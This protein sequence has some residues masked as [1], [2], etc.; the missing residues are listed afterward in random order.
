M[1]YRKNKQNRN[2][3]FINRRNKFRFLKTATV[4]LCLA[5]GLTISTV[6]AEEEVK[7]IYHVY[8]DGTYLGKVND[9]AVIQNII[10]DKIA[11]ESKEYENLDL[12]IG[13]DLNYVSEKVFSPSY[14]NEAVAKALES[15]ISVMA[16]AIEL[17]IGNEI[18]GYFHDQETADEVIQEYKSQ[19]VDEEDLERLE[20]EKDQEEED[21]DE[22]EV[23]ERPEPSLQLGDTIISEVL[24]TEEI[25]T[26]EGEIAPNDLLTKEEGLTLL[27]KGTLEEK[28]HQV[29]EGEVLGGIASKYELSMEKLL[30]INPSITEDTLI[31]IGQEINVMDYEPFVDVIVKE[32]TLVEES[33][34]YETEVIESDDLYKGEEKVQQEGKD[35]KKEVHYVIE[36]VNGFEEKKEKIEETVTEEPVNKVIIKGTKV[37]PSRGTGNL[38]WPAVGGYVSSK[39]GERWGKMHKGI[40]IA[41]PSNRN[42]LAADNGVIESAG[43]SGGYGNKIVINH[44]NGMKTIYAHLASM[45]VKVGQTVEKG[46]KIGVMGSTGNSTGIH[47]HFEVYENGALKDPLDYI[48]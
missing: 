20:S 22:S 1:S 15:E 7:T 31:Q 27:E 34:N 21:L 2:Q 9:E 36:T 24:L 26:S 44:N 42:I 29:S 3:L 12:T 45:D 11:E 38:S 41:R 43:Y 4:S 10:D 13:E 32:E 19:Y 25:T 35:G 6:H 37:I 47:L 28:V 46:K 5:L 48:R 23:E 39:M 40:D 8:M 33:I 14:D 16:E 30:E 18:V 17:K